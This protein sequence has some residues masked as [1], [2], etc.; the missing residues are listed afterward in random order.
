[1]V[2]RLLDGAVPSQIE[3]VPLDQAVA[4]VAVLCPR[5]RHQLRQLDESVGVDIRCVDIIVTD[6]LDRTV[7][8]CKRHVL[9][10]PATERKHIRHDSFLGIHPRCEHC[11]DVP[12]QVARDDPPHRLHACC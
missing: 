7:L 10:A 6:G 12:R 5:Q 8:V 9:K 2:G 3:V 11:R 4:V 1:M